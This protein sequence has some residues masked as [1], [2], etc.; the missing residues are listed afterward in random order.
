ML[1]WR[2]IFIAVSAAD[3]V[4][5]EMNGDHLQTDWGH[6]Q[7]AYR[8][9]GIVLVLGA[10]V[11]YDSGLPNWPGLLERVADRLGDREGLFGD[12]Q[13]SGIPLEV[14][15]SILE[16]Q[17]RSGSR[18]S[19]S[20]RGKFIE[21]VR[22]ALYQEFPFFPG[23]VT[24]T[25]RRKFVR[26]VR[27]S[28]PTLRAVASL[29]ARRKREDRTYTPNPRVR[30]VVTFNLDAVL[31]AY[32]YARYEKRLLRTVERASAQAFTGRI[33][34]YHMHGFLRFD[35]WVNDP[36]REAPD[37]VVLTEQDY[38]NFFGD[39]TSLFNYTFL[40]LLREWPC[41]F[42]GLSMRDENIRRLL[43]VSTTERVRGMKNA[44]WK[45]DRIDR[46]AL[47][48]FAI[49]RRSDA[50]RSDDADHAFEAS[51]RPLGTSVLWIDDYAEIQPQLRKMYEAADSD[52]DLVY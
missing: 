34:V 33:N 27:T 21:H 4:R 2:R 25:N 46:E 22:A 37:A 26:N 31:Q 48:H 42:V 3:E 32:V 14:V 9:H 17:C 36:A 52:W 40:Y 45:R 1:P 6:L 49:L 43:H 8:E 29:C 39:P 35:R 15:A 7:T 50:S 19:R 23:G 41:L 5:S 44:G 20:R 16:E 13:R 28:N 11:S 24:K 18:S 47:R 51:L 38:F 10:G 30:A 12:L